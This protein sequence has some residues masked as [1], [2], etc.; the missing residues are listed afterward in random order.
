[1]FVLY[2]LV[3]NG[4]NYEKDNRYKVIKFFI[5]DYFFFFLSNEIYINYNIYRYL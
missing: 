1:M 4:D 2:I 3:F 5:I